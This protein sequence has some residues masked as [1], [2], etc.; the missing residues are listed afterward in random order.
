M[1]GWLLS[2]LYSGLSFKALARAM[3][4][5]P[6]AELTALEARR[7]KDKTTLAGQLAVAR[8]G[9]LGRRIQL[10][11]PLRAQAARFRSPSV[12]A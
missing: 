5:V 8:R 10:R 4:R 12:T 2:G 1:A 9:R 3:G 6:T 11:R 7:N